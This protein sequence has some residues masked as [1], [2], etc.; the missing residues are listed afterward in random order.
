[1]DGCYKSSHT[2]Q[3]RQTMVKC[4]Q[5]SHGVSLIYSIRG[6]YSSILH[7]L[8]FSFGS[9]QCISEHL[10]SPADRPARLGPCN[11]QGFPTHKQPRDTSVSPRTSSHL[12]LTHQIASF[13]KALIA[14]SP[15]RYLARDSTMR[16]LGIFQQALWNKVL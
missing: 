12:E 5:T 9:I 11:Q 4:I 15:R 6:I 2:M 3:G 16:S 14:S 1:M 13:D 7:V 8:I 10:G